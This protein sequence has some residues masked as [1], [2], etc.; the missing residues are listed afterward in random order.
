MK[1][2]VTLQG[3]SFL[4]N[5]IFIAVNLTGLTFLVMGYHDNFVEQS[6]LFKFIGII[7]MI[8]SIAGLILFRGRY[9]MSSVSRVLVGGLFIVSGLVKAN[10]PLGFSYKL[11][12]YFEDG[13]LAFRIKEWFGLPGFSL[14]V[15]IDYALILSVVICIAEIVLGVLTIIGGKIKLVSYLMMI[16]MVFFT[17]LTWHTAN[18]DKDQR[19]ADHDTY[20]MTDP[21]AQLKIDEA[22]YNEDVTVLSTSSSEVVI[23]E[24]KT[25]QCVSDCGCFGDAMKGSVGRSLSPKESLW[26]D[27]ILVYLVLW[28]FIAQWIIKPNTRKQNMV[29]GGASVVMIVFFS[30]VF[31]WYFPVFFG[32]ISILGAL[33]ILRIGGKFLGNYYGSSLIVTVICTLMVTY[34]LMYLPLKDYRSYAVGTNL[35]EKM[36]DGINGE[37]ESLLVYKNTIT[38]ETIEYSSTSEEY[39]ASKIWEDTDWVYESMVQKEIIAMKIPSIDTNQF[40]PF[41]AIDELTEAE[42]ALPFIT[43]RMKDAQ[44]K[45]LSIYDVVANST[46]EI[47]LE[48]YNVTDYPEDS[49]SIVDTVSFDNPD[50]TEIGI[51]KDVIQSD[52]FVLV[53]AK[54]LK[55][56]NWSRLDRLK[57]IFALCKENNVPFVVICSASRE[58]INA[59]REENSFDAPFFVNDE[60]ELKA[61]T[62]SNPTIM[63]IEKGIVVAKYPCRSTPSKDG[64]KTKHLN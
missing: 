53:V 6:T 25:P 32:I 59:F 41:V 60:T 16:M 50:F 47:P 28:I 7:L 30:W 8:L 63:V 23:E 37:F 31:G 14:E 33:W 5:S 34:V 56:G 4:I 1:E 61:M 44:M 57:D 15:F 24:M 26:K 3:R 43:E 10:D 35:F 52:K 17:F 51:W 58:D 2:Q 55:K 39:M 19:F 22:E 11:E 54:D 49:Y 46:Y 36:T 20:A 12:E 18:C 29:Y 48:E 38:G 13:A 9:L 62:R 27:I 40:N 21:L 42:L 64:F 45:E